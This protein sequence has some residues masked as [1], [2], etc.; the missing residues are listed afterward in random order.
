MTKIGDLT[1]CLHTDNSSINALSILDS[2][3]NCGWDLVNDGEIWILPIEDTDFDWKIFK[4]TER[5]IVL[6]IIQNKYIRNELIGVVMT[7]K[8]TGH[9]VSMLLQPDLKS[10]KVICNI[11]QKMLK[12]LN[13]VDFSWYLMKIIPILSKLKITIDSITCDYS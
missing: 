9:G 3:L 7:Y 6:N 4:D 1:F 5:D 8:L 12:D 10:I 13:V 2:F 11:N